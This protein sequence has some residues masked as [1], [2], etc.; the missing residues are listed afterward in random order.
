MLG[1][2]DL[3][4]EIAS[5][6]RP[7]PVSVE[8]RVIAR[9]DNAAIQRAAEKYPT[10]PSCNEAGLVRPAP[11]LGGFRCRQ[12]GRTMDAEGHVTSEFEQVIVGATC[13]GDAAAIFQQTGKPHAQKVSNEL[14][15]TACGQQ[16]SRRPQE[17]APR[18]ISRRDRLGRLGSYALRAPRGRF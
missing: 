17:P 2:L 13:C 15:C 12:C 11:V 9:V 8:Q 5:G 6:K 18:G 16:S 10:C 3:Y 7:L 14:R 1:L 4:K